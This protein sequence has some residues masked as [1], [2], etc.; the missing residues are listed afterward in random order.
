MKHTAVLTNGLKQ[1][2][3]VVAYQE[4]ICVQIVTSMETQARPEVTSVHYSIRLI[5]H[6]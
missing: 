5:P 6:K 3:I 4:H 1:D 2:G